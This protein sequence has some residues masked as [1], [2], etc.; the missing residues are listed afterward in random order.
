V[1]MITI[2]LHQVSTLRTVFW[3]CVKMRSVVLRPTMLSCACAPS[4]ANS[5]QWTRVLAKNLRVSSSWVP[6]TPPAK[7]LSV[8]LHQ[9]QLLS[10]AC[11]LAHMPQ[12]A[13]VIV[14]AA[15]A[16]AAAAAAHR[17]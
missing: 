15:A 8:L 13:G 4:R 2:L 12:C 6:I 11:A 9:L 3:W 7:R 1:L 5:S 16:A 14:H 17:C 10:A